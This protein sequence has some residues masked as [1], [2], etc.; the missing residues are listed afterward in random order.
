[1]PY[2]ARAMLFI[3]AIAAAIICC[4]HAA[5]PCRS[6]MLVAAAYDAAMPATAMPCRYLRRYA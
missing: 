5:M 2:A 6:L 1:M 4:C 3:D